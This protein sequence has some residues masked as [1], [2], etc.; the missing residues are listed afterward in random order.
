MLR[1]C[2][3]KMKREQLSVE[4]GITMRALVDFPGGLELHL[5]VGF[6]LALA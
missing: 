1:V 2:R 4:D 6:G 5:G 3:E